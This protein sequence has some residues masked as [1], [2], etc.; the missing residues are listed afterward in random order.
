VETS[1]KVTPG[2]LEPAPGSYLVYSRAATGTGTDGKQIEHAV[3]FTQQ[4]GTVFGFSAAVDG[5]MTDPDARTKT[6]GIRATR[7]DEQALWEFAPSGTK[8]VVVR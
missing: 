1:F 2:T 5:S 4:S 7:T 8:V 3:R 6:G